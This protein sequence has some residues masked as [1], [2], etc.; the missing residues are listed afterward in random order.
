MCEDVHKEKLNKSVYP[1]SQVGVVMPLVLLPGWSFDRRIWQDLIESLQRVIPVITLNLPGFGDNRWASWSG[2]EDLCE[3]ILQTMPPRA[4]YMGW[5]L[6]GMLATKIAV[7]FPER[8]AGII[9]LATNI[10]FVERNHWPHGMAISDFRNFH[11]GIAKAPEQTL[12]RFH[13]LISQGDQL[14]RQQFRWLQTVAAKTEDYEHLLPMLSL[15]ADIDNR[16]DIHKL[17]IPGLHIFGESDRLVPASVIQ[18]L[19]GLA[20]YHNHNQQQL[21]LLKSTGH[22][23][24][25]PGDRIIPLVE[26]FLTEHYGH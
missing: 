12:K 23:V 1:C 8:V 25:W 9:T 16:E 3:K 13:L 10:S 18:K 2:V 17:S 19:S 24:F 6:G 14:H 11:K 20:T 21:H 7:T 5:S 26:A 22:L 15:L 4:I